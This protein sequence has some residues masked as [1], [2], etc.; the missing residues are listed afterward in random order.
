MNKEDEPV[1]PNDE[2]AVE[3]A[4]M[5]QKQKAKTNNKKR[6]VRHTKIQT[7]TGATK[8]DMDL[9][10]QDIEEEPELRQHMNLYKD[11]DVIK[12][13]EAQIG[14]MTLEDKDQKPIKI[15]KRKTEKGKESA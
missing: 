1:D 6:K 7:A 5:K 10:L 15:A 13:L 12:Q 9:F 14:G 3:L 11:E 4:R 2:E 8:K